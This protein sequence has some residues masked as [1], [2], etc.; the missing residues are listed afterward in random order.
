VVSFRD[1]NQLSEIPRLQQHLQNGLACD[2][3]IIGL[4]AEKWNF[5]LS[6]KPVI[7][8]MLHAK[9]GPAP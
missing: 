4:F 8:A 7:L 2:R 6:G 5:T 9:F 1:W 3:A